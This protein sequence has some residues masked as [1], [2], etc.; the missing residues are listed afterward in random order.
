[1]HQERGRFVSPGPEQTRICLT[2]DAQIVAFET[3][4]LQ[5]VWMGRELLLTL[6]GRS[7]GHGACDLSDRL[8]EGRT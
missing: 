1:M 7:N 2:R 3:I 8:W 5:V 6:F 4:A